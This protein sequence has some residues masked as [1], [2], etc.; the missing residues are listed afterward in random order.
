MYMVIPSAIGRVYYIHQALTQV[1]HRWVYLSNNF[2]SKIPHWK[3]I[4]QSMDT[5]LTYLV[6]I[7]PRLATDLGFIDASSI[8]ASGVRIDPSSDREHFVWCVESPQTQ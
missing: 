4:C 5:R 8:G 3:R 2:H 6:E 1:S 7:V